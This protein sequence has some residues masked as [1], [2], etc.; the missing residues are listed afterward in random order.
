MVKK[1]SGSKS[2]Q[3]IRKNTWDISLDSPLKTVKNDAIQM[4]EKNFS[5]F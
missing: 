4:H 3:K 1:W 2:T 5:D